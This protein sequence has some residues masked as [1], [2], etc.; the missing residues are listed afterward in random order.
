LAQLGNLKSP[1]QAL[2]LLLGRIICNSSWYSPF[3]Q[4]S[5]V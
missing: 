4:F 1:Y 3:Y 5:S 2:S